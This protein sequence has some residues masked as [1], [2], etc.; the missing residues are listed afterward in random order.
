MKTQGLKLREY[1]ELMKKAVAPGQIDRLLLSAESDPLVSTNA[2]HMLRVKAENAKEKLIRKQY[3]WRRSCKYWRNPVGHGLHSCEYL[4]LTGKSRIKQIPDRRQRRNY[5]ACPCFD[6]GK[7]PMP[8]VVRNTAHSKY[9]WTLGLAL[10]GAGATDRQ[11]A[12]ALGCTSKT[13]KWWRRKNRLL[14]NR[15]D[16]RDGGGEG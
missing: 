11:I 9:D 4:T 14:C 10:H 12:E 6:Q 13:V 16:A 5:D 1:G 7:K 3:C 15:E 2:L 8:K